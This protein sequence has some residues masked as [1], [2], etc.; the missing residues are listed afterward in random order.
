MPCNCNH[1]GSSLHQCDPITGECDCNIGIGGKKCDECARGY[2]GTSP[3]CT[4]CGECFENWDFTINKLK[5]K[6]S[7]LIDSASAIRRSGAT[8][9]Y[10]AEFSLMEERIEDVRHILDTANT[11]SRDLQHL[12]AVI[13]ELRS[14]ME[15]HRLELLSLESGVDNTTQRISLASN[16]LATLNTKAETLRTEATNLKKKGTKLQEANVE[17]ALNS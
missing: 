17:G 11:T 5:D 15:S 3:Y 13:D 2:S 4:E 1:E 14:E 7:E 10:K 8:G 16:S 12:N 9:A 6:T